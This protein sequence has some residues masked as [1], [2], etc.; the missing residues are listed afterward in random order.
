MAPDKSFE[1]DLYTLNESTFGQIALD[2]FRSQ[3]V[4]NPVYHSYLE[5]LRITPDS[6]TDV[7]SIPFLPI[8]FFKTHFLQTGQ[9][10]PQAVYTSSGTTGI[11][12]SRHPVASVSSYLDLASKHFENIFGPLRNY[13]ILALLPSYL[14]RPDSSLVAMVRGFIERSNSP[15]SSFFNTDYQALIK[16]LAL[17]PGDQKILLWGVS[18]ALL[19]LAGYEIPVLPNLVV[20][21]TG[22]MKGRGK[23]ITRDELHHKLKQAFHTEKIYSEYGMTE[24]LSQA[25]TRGL[26]RFYPAPAM[27]VFARD[28]TDPFR[29]GVNSGRLNIIDLANYKTLSFVET[30]DLGTVYPDGSFEVLGRFDNS[31]MRGCNL[32]VQ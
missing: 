5:Y 14:D 31:D 1:S 8:S 18:F 28:I 3:A 7:H 20:M 9:W 12:T 27:K 11:T 17:I 13:H 25:Y 4:G 21:E 15:F 16:V 23:E 32:L 10:Q 26:N 6:V 24:L 22:G 19:D 2:V 29:V 30:E